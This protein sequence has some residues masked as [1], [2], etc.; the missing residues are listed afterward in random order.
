MYIYFAFQALVFGSI[1]FFGVFL[2]VGGVACGHGRM[3]AGGVLVGAIRALIAGVVLRATWRDYGRFIKALN[4]DAN[5]A[6]QVQ[7]QWRQN[8]K[9]N[10]RVNDPLIA[11]MCLALTLVILFAEDAP[12]WMRILVPIATGAGCLLFVWKSIHVW[13]A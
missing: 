5:A 4:G 7:S 12:L 10:R 11:F 2:L 13:R 6:R 3:G 8:L 9:W 1:G